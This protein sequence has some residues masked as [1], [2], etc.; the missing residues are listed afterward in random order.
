MNDRITK[1]LRWLKEH[2]KR[3]EI[4]CIGETIILSILSYHVPLSDTAKELLIRSADNCVVK[5]DVDRAF[6]SYAKSCA[7]SSP[8]T[9]ISLGI[10]PKATMD[11]LMKLSLTSCAFDEYQKSQYE[12][13]L[14]NCFGHLK[15]HHKG[16]F[17]FYFLCHYVMAVT[18]FGAI[19]VHPEDA[20]SMNSVIEMGSRG[21]PN[22]M[23][24]LTEF[25]LTQLYLGVLDTEKAIK[26]L[27]STQLEDGSFD[28]GSAQYD[29]NLHSTLMALWL[30][31]EIIGERN[32]NHQCI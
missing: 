30:M 28:R 18:A 15:M 29:S 27:E 26:H 12:I 11:T 9:R 31:A 7:N 5:D 14:D 2:D 23:D 16:E 32:D 17:D 3:N 1:A 4:E 13:T 25:Y 6:V 8:L 22:N 21:F 20:L 24:L 19:E 10:P